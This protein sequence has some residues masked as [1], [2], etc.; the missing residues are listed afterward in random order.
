MTGA[1][2]S[3]LRRRFL[4]AGSRRWH[5]LTGGAGPALILIHGSPG[6]S[7]LVKPLAQ[8]LAARYRVYAF[9]SPGFGGSDPLPG[10]VLTVAELADAYRDALDAAGLEQVAVFGTHTGAA[11][12]LELARRHPTRIAAF[13]LE[14][15]PIFT[16]EE[17]RPLLTPEYMPHF[18]PDMLG[19]QYARAWTRFHDQYLWFPWNERDPQ[20]LNET[21]AGSAADLHKWV[22]MYFQAMRHYRPAYRAAIAYGEG[23]VAAARELRVPGV[24]LAERADMLFRHLDRLPPL[25][26][27][28]RIERIVGSAGVNGRIASAFDSL[29]AAAP[30]VALPAVTAGLAEGFYDHDEGQILVRSAGA[31]AG[32]GAGAGAGA[33]ATVPIL[34][35]HDAPGGGRPLEPLF[36]ALAAHGRVLLPDLPGCGQSSALGDTVPPLA[37]YAD[38][39]AALIRDRIG[40]PVAVYGVGVG[41]AVALE[42]NRRH[43]EEVLALFLTGT[44]RIDGAA[45]RA[46][47][48]RLAPPIRLEWDGAHWYRTWLMLR[49]SLVHQP[50][51]DREVATLR[52]QRTSFD[53]QRLHDWTLDVMRQ[54]SAYHHVIDAALLWSPE[55]PLAQAAGKITVCIDAEHALA[56][57]DTAWAATPGVRALTLDPDA[58]IRAQQLA[59][60][61]NAL[62]T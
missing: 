15:V 53:P 51:F 30:G 47:V 52:R 33:D 40:R 23:A 27:G 29:A 16:P 49:D 57:A 55:A 21:R 58:R 22:E 45:R 13:V 41:A 10:A 50:W 1:S 2:G 7:T 59:S 5:L 62:R 60:T 44:E 37:D 48:G 8:Q 39:L 17:Q 14:G 4:L 43:P 11:I 38:A 56:A 35:L 54:W 26:P 34:L 18:D 20:H 31:D 19:G 28:Q 61:L 9:D 46:L 32:A 12:G 36:R 6:N 25:A 24:Y 3:A 42:L